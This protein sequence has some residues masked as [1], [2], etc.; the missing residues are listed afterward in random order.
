MHDRIRLPWPTGQE[1]VAA[2]A[3]STIQNVISLSWIWQTSMLWERALRLWE[4]Y[5]PVKISQSNW[6]QLL[7]NLCINPWN[8]SWFSQLEGS[9]W[10]QLISGLLRAAVA[11]AAAMEREARPVLVHCSDGWDRTPQIVALA[12]LLLDPYYRTIEVRGANHMIYLQLY[13]CV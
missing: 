1:V 6:G 4:A 10:F 12:Q 13:W 11:V 5:V 2:S 7:I 9:R 3:L 8:F